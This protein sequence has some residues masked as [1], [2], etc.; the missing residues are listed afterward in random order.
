MGG[1]HTGAPL[2]PAAAS[3]RR[4]HAEAVSIGV[5][6]DGGAAEVQGAG[7]LQDGEAARPQRRHGGI[8]VGHREGDLAR[9][10]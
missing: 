10:G 5:E 2:S 6:H 4:E 8:D 9:P 3:A 7:L 1:A